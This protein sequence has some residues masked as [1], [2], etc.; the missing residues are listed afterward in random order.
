MTNCMIKVLH[1]FSVTKTFA[2]FCG[3]VFVGNLYSLHLPWSSM[4]CACFDFDSCHLGLRE[5]DLKS[6][7]V[8]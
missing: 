8:T 6:E 1:H 2:I 4:L 7:L 5:L 3:T